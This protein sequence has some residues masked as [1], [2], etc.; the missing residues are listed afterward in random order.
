MVQNF[1]DESCFILST[2][3]AETGA[4][5]HVILKWIPKNCQDED[6]DLTLSS[7]SIEWPVNKLL[8]PL[9]VCSNVEQ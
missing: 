9:S 4:G 6:W 7:G 3:K 1:Q 8:V 5:Y 2:L